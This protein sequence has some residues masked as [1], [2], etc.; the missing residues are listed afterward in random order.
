MEYTIVIEK[1]PTSYG[2]H[3]LENSPA[4]SPTADTREEASTPHPRSNRSTSKS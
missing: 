3:V 4:V 2:A 1:G